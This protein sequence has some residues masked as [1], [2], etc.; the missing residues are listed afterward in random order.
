MSRAA[1][2]SDRGVTPHGRPGRGSGL[3]PLLWRRAA[4]IWRPDRRAAAPEGIPDL[5]EDPYRLSSLDPPAWRGWLHGAMVLPAVA[6]GV[7][8]VAATPG[9]GARAVVALYAAG[10]VT[11]FAV[12]AAFHLRR[13]SD[14]GWLRMRR[15]DHTAIFILIAA[16]YGAIM[17]L[18]V[19][20]WPRTWLVGAAVVLCAGGIAVRWLLLHPPFRLMTTLFLATGGASLIAIRQILRGLDVLGTT[21]VLVGCAVYGLGALA[22]GLLR[23]NP[24]PA[25]FGYHEVWH[26]NV[27][28]AVGCQYWVVACVVVPSL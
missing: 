16:S 13:W 8:L 12:S 21:V 19:P 7:W 24:W 4:S 20:G 9:V 10:V 23:P 27:T 3:L 2:R 15:W 5:S 11:M 28:I 14:E 18:G 6:A 17:G 25:R 22:L 1:A 26:L